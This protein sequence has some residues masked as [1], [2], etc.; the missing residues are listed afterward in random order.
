MKT[1]MTQGSRRKQHLDPLQDAEQEY[2][3]Y[4]LRGMRPMK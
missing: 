4:V 2:K 3:A 1:L